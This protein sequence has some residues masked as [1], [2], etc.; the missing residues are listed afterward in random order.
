[1][2]KFFQILIVLSIITAAGL[3]LYVYLTDKHVIVYTNGTI[4]TVDDKDV[5][6]L[7]DGTI[8]Y[9]DSIIEQEEVKYYSKRRIA[10]IFLDIRNKAYSKWNRFDSTLNIISSG[11]QVAIP[12]LILVLIFHFLIRFLFRRQAQETPFKDVVVVLVSFLL[13]HTKE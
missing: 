6:F 12:L 5:I 3:A 9:D 2:R 4:Q 13:F 8:L 7:N 1:M 10:H 11:F